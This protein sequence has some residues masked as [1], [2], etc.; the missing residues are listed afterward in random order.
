MK[1]IV[2]FVLAACL[3]AFAVPAMA[4]TS[5][6]NNSTSIGWGPSVAASV[7]EF[8]PS[9]GNCQLITGGVFGGLAYTWANK[10]NVNS[11]GLY[12]GPQSSVKGSVTTTSLDFM[13]YLNL[14]QTQRYGGFGIGLVTRVF[15]SGKSSSKAISLANTG[16]VLGIQF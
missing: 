11:M 8:F 13:L 2:L 10:Q 14:L 9:K 1:A 5:F 4:N 7:S 6:S 3:L 16:L 15:E 12:F